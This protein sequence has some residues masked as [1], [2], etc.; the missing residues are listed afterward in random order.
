M[1]AYLEA[2]ADA[3]GLGSPLFP[4]GAVQASDWAVIEK[5]ARAFTKAYALFDRLE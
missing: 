3:F 5:E 4:A 2:G 1:R